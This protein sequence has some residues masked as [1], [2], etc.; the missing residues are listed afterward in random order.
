MKSAGCLG[1]IDRSSGRGRPGDG[2]VTAGRQGASTGG[3]EFAEDASECRQGNE[4][5][6]NE[7]RREFSRDFREWPAEF[8][9]ACCG[10]IW[11]V[12]GIRTG[13][14][15]RDFVNS[16]RRRGRGGRILERTGFGG[17][18]SERGNSRKEEKSS[19]K[20]IQGEMMDGCEGTWSNSQWI[21]GD[22]GREN[23]DE[24]EACATD[25]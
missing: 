15:R 19:G 2:R 13:E 6:K 8:N 21:D 11:Q 17:N 22:F 4:E 25:A 7:F 3:D 1:G 10:G 18:L 16:W 20:G 5:G 23:G 24:R 9:G 14:F 12:V